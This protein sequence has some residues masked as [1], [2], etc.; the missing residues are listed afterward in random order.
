M[1]LGCHGDVAGLAPLTVRFDYAD[2]TTSG[3]LTLGASRPAEPENVLSQT[4]RDGR[5]RTRVIDC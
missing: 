4:V 5:G 1:L 3:W 2:G